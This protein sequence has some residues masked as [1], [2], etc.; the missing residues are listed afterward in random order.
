M[1]ANPLTDSM[2]LES[3]EGFSEGYRPSIVRPKAS[4]PLN[5]QG[6]NTQST[7]WT[8]DDIII[9]VVGNAGS[10]KTTFINTAASVDLPVGHGM[11]PC[12]T[13]ISATRLDIRALTNHSII[14]VDTP[15][16]DVIKTTTP[17]VIKAVTEWLRKAYRKKVTLSGILFVQQIS[18]TNKLTFTSVR[19]SLDILGIKPSCPR[20]RLVTT[21]WE[22][23]D[24]AIAQSNEKAIFSQWSRMVV[25]PDL[26]PCRFDVTQLSSVRIIL[27]FIRSA[28]QRTACR[29]I[30]ELTKTIHNPNLMKIL[31]ELLDHRQATLSRLLE[32]LEKPD[33]NRSQLEG[34]VLEHQEIS[35][36]LH[37]HFDAIRPLKPPF[38]DILKG[39]VNWVISWNWV[40]SLLGPTSAS[41][42]VI[43]A[44]PLHIKQAAE[45]ISPDDKVVLL[46]GLTGSGKSQFISDCVGFDVGIND[47]LI[48]KYTSV[49]LV[50]GTV[51]DSRIAF[52]DTPGFDQPEAPTDVDILKQIRHWLAALHQCRVRLTGVIFLHNITVNLTPQ[53]F[54]P[55]RGL[56][57]KFLEEGTSVTLV[58]THWDQE[59]PK[60][61][62]ILQEAL[63]TGPWKR[64]IE[65][66]AK[67]KA[68][69]KGLGSQ[70]VVIPLEPDASALS[71][72]Q[73]IT[74]LVTRG[75]S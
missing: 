39:A 54:L 53:L 64:V 63:T 33:P 67:P 75:E 3:Q 34:L 4:F 49:N 11:N 45:R 59:D 16:L 22:D 20:I 52:L 32:E 48:P 26:I 30:E 23:V 60:E 37:L 42:G 1:N 58:G 72:L 18:D 62:R 56:L 66:G 73:E 70:D 17:N 27:P 61:A 69:G 68:L 44:L 41:E 6:K 8:D 7:D 13:T 21:M 14:L 36:K 31:S 50:E 47:D 5:I 38:S 43:E 65:L 15:G 9:A 12:T 28:N 40:S 55:S 2:Q 29:L 24:V 25:N 35:E 10:G 51:K 57:S 71:I 74:G 19:Q 46:L